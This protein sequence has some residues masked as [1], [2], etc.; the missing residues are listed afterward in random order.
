[1]KTE[2]TVASIY[3]DKGTVYRSY[4]DGWLKAVDNFDKYVKDFKPKRA[5][6]FH[7]N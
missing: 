3:K 4:H 7:N 1:M 2:K 6:K 5:Y